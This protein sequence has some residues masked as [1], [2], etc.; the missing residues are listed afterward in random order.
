MCTLHNVMSATKDRKQFLG[1]SFYIAGNYRT[2]VIIATYG[3][4]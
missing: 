3:E 4:I 1:A 2:N